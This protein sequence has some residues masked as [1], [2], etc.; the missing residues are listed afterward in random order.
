[1]KIGVP[2]EIKPYENRVGLTP[3]GALTLARAGHS[4]LVEKGAGKG[5]GFEDSDYAGAGATIAPTAGQ[6]FDAAEMIVKVKEPLPAEYPLLRKDQIL[7]TY[8][9]LAAERELTQALVERG[10]VAIAYETV[11]N[12]DRSLPL[13]TPMSEVAGRMAVQI[14][15]HFLEKYQG[16]RGILLGGVPGVQP[17]NVVVIGGGVVGTNAARIAV[18]M[19]ANVTLYDI[20][21]DR[22][23]YLDDVFLGRLQTRMSNEYSIAAATERADLLVGAVLVPGAKA[24]SLVSEAMVKTMAPGAVIVDVSIDQGGCIAT[25]DHTSSHAEPTYVRHNVLHYAVPNMPGAVPRTST[26]ALTN[27]TTPFVVQ[28]ANK[29]WKKALRENPALARGAN[30]VEG[31]VVYEAVAKAQGMAFVPSEFGSAA[32]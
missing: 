23:R 15:A 4:V 21:A 16:G 13:L 26:Y 9:H 22:L 14:G 31:K 3:V 30:V 20:S 27:V 2:K 10:V 17:A 12:P 5:S 29:G 19:G 24:P 11:Q 8:L 7:F 25:C 18:G 28:I 6:V 1:M 32:R